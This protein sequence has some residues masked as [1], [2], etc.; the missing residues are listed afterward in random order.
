MSGTYANSTPTFGS[1]IYKDDGTGSTP[2][3]LQPGATSMSSFS[4][5]HAGIPVAGS[6]TVVVRDSSG[7]S[8]TSNSFAVVAAKMVTPAAP[9]NTVT[10]VTYTF[11][12]TLSG[13]SSPPTLTYSLDGGTATAVT[14]VTN[15]A[16]SMNLTGPAAGQHTIVVSDNSNPPV[17]GS[18]TFTTAAPAKGISVTM[19]T[20]VVAGATFPFAGTLTNYT[21]IPALTYSF[22]GNVTKNTLGGVTLTGWSTT[23][24]APAT[25]GSTT[26]IVSDGTV[27]GQSTFTVAAAAKVITVTAI[28]SAV[29]GTTITF[30]GTLSGYTAVPTLTYSLDAGGATAVTGVTATAWSMTIT[31]PAAGAHTITVTDGT[32]TSPVSNFTTTAVVKTIAPTAPSGTVQNVAFTFVGVLTGFGVSTPTLTYSID[33]A[34]P[35]ALTGVSPT[36]WSA[37]VTV[38][39]AGSHTIVVTDAADVLTGSTSFTTAAAAVKTIVPAAPAGTTQ[40]VA[41]TFTGTLSG[42]TTAPTL[43]YRLNNGAAVPMTGVTATG[44]SM[45]IAVGPSG[46]N[47][48][49]VSDGSNS[50]SVGFTTAVATRTILPVPPSLPVENA[51][52]TFTGTYN[53]YSS[54]PI[55]QY[56]ID[57]GPYITMTGVVE[58]AD[59]AGVTW[60]AAGVSQGGTGTVDVQLATRAN[61]PGSVMPSSTNYNFYFSNSGNKDTDWAAWSDFDGNFNITTSRPF[62]CYQITIC[63]M[64]GYRV[65][66]YGYDPA[67]FISTARQANMQS[68]A[69]KIK[70]KGNAFVTVNPGWEWN[71]GGY[72]D[73][74]FDASGQQT[75]YITWFRMFSKIIKD[76]NP[77][78]LIAWISNSCLM[79]FGTLNDFYPGSDRVDVIGMEC[80]GG[81]STGGGGQRG[82]ANTLISTT[83]V[84]NNWGWC[85][86]NSSGPTLGANHPAKATGSM[87]IQGVSTPIPTYGPKL[88]G[89]PEWQNNPNDPNYVTNV[90]AWTQNAAVKGRVVVLNY[91]QG[92]S[93]GGGSPLTNSNAVGDQWVAANKDNFFP[94]LPVTKL[95]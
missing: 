65:P 68:M 22:D 60:P 28:P 14:G 16:W 90:F 75:N 52:F 62:D 2:V 46:S 37:S 58:N 45:V 32:I 30:A 81:V 51:T 19:P 6:H 35:V 42:Y 29:A 49:L 55:L 85:A 67:D 12:G 33:N 88:I 57:S 24:T 79:N 93:Q 77:N 26:V 10:G 18:A 23:L 72:N 48:L 91:W 74:G 50:G 15:T 83:D 53:G 11:S 59:A 27:N 92:D 78:V 31:A 40:D 8:A 86:V 38:V 20:G 80:Y 87:M 39:S 69:D 41:F 5:I 47:T 17:T 54:A 64:S 25:A 76:T 34:A 9:A 1:L 44:W 94:G 95:S 13:Y 70:A 43:T 21:A 89:I 61:Q 7:A 84:T 71:S 66:R 63:P 73:I 3:P 4:F 36:G 56:K 82:N